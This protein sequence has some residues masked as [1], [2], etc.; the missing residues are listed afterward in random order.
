MRTTVYL[1]FDARV[2]AMKF[3]RDA[4]S[5][6]ALSCCTSLESVLPAVNLWLGLR[7]TKQIGIVPVLPFQR[8][9]EQDLIK[10]LSLC[11]ELNDICC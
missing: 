8:E 6:L 3:R 7:S 5:R 2:K 11:S 9:V 1:I 4:Q 10:T